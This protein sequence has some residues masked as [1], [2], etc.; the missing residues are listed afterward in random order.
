MRTLAEQAAKADALVDEATAAGGGS[1]SVT[2]HAKML[3]LELLNVK[4]D[5]ERELE[6][7]V[8]D[9]SSWGRTVHW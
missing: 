8:L 9:C 4:A 6:Q 2:V 7:L 3:R 5:L 1:H